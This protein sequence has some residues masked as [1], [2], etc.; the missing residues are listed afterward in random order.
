MVRGHFKRGLPSLVNG[1]GFRPQSLSVRR[2]K[3]CPPH[4]Q[5]Q[6]RSIFSSVALDRL[7]LCR[8]QAFASPLPVGVFCHRSL[9][10]LFVQFVCSRSLTVCLKKK[11]NDSKKK[12]PLKSKLGADDQEKKRNVGKNGTKALPW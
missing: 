12:A 2:F 7:S 4:H 8:V 1:A 10:L 3:S 5:T 6:N 9:V 11:I